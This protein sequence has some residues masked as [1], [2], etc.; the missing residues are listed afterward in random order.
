[1]FY[2]GGDQ[3]FYYQKI[4]NHV[5][6]TFSLNASTTAG[7]AGGAFTIQ[8]LPFTSANIT[9]LRTIGTH[10][11]YYNTGLR[12]SGWPNFIHVSSTVSYADVYT[13]TSTSGAYDRATVNQVGS[14]TYFFWQVT[15]QTD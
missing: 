12:A 8:G 1:M 15:Y 10:V 3:Q 9:N 7:T 4:G 5:T 13:K 2:S 14:S 6:V 11:V